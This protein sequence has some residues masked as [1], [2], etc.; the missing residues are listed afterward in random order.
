MAQAAGIPT[1]TVRLYQNKGLLS[2]PER[3]G[4][5]GYY[6]AAHRDRLRLIAH[7]QERGFSLAAIKES[8]DY[9]NEGRSLAHLLGI[10]DIAPHLGRKP[11]RL[12]ADEFAQ[13]YCDADLTQTDIQRAAALGLIELDGT[14]V[15]VFNAAFLDIGRDVARLEIPLS[16]ILDEYEYVQAAIGDVAE[17]FRDVFER[18]FWAPFVERGLPP[19]AIRSLSSAVR[20]LTDLASQVVTEELH[21]RFSAFAEHY[22]ARAS[23][24]SSEGS[25]D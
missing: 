5:V 4:R 1:S 20:Q 15:V 17:R 12:S 18:H 22:L 19:S 11:L 13:R 2:P 24:H 10:N 7:L 14:E 16:E 9:W 25:G 23:A 6:D 21:Q 3:R 8:L